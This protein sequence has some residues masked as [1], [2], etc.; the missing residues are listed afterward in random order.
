MTISEGC[1]PDNFESHNSLKLSFVNISGLCLNFVGCE[2]L[3]ES[4]SPDIL[5]LYETNWDH[6]IDSGNFSVTSY[7]PL[8]CKDSI[9]HMH[10][11]A[12]YV[13]DGLSFA[14]DLHLEN[15]TDLTFVFDWPLSGLLYQSPSS[16]WT[17]LDSISSGIDEV[18]LVNPFANVFFYGDLNILHKDWLTYY[19]GTDKPGEFSY[20]FSIWNN[21]T[22]MINF[23]AWITD[24][25][26]HSPAILVL[27][28]SSDPSSCSVM[29][30][31]LLRIL[32]IW[33]SQFPMTFHQTQNSLI[34][35]TA[36]LMTILVLVGMIFMII[37]EIFHGKK[38]LHSEILLLLVNFV[39]G[40]RLEVVYIAHHHYKVKPHSFPWFSAACAIGLVHTIFFP[41]F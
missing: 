29:A 19:G 25:G 35:F 11:L 36:K 23:P 31:P 39:G 20:N 40:F 16:L 2:S 15:S 28:L 9:A 8:I 14:Q 18:L 12:V 41:C 38:S 37:W 33:L 6:S 34:Q 21:L 4:N 32:I 26:S 5:A 17:V 1:K 30:F 24:C 7:L 10:G 22:Q 13:K 3:L 27:F